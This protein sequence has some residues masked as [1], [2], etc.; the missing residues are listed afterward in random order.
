MGTNLVL[1]LFPQW[2]NRM[3]YVFNNYTYSWSYIW[4]KIISNVV[5]LL[6]MY[7]FYTHTQCNNTGFQK[8][9]IIKSFT[10]EIKAAISACFTCWREYSSFYFMVNKTEHIE[11][12][13]SSHPTCKL[14]TSATQLL[15]C[16]LFTGI[17][18]K[19]K[20]YRTEQQKL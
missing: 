2:K 9:K 7:I 13:F 10:C 8:K 1:K 17:N 14:N 19:Q 6:Y 12:Y 11:T 18:H 4:L 16:A 3:V 15:H 20:N 5:L